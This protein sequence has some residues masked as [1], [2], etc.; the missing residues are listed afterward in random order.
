IDL[1]TGKRTVLLSDP[2]LDYGGPAFSPDGLHLACL[3]ASHFTRE[4]PH[5]ETLLLVGSDGT[6]EARALTG[7][8]DRWP[9]SPVWDPAGRWVYFT[10]DD[11]GRR[12]ALR[13]GGRHGGGRG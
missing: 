6:G 11:T 7:D 13:G 5:D 9:G 12:P 1:A 4:E 10:A 3:C 2:D 8:L